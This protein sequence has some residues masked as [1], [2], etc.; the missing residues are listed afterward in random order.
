MGV[1]PE[2]SVVDEWGRAHDVPNLYVA[3]GSVFVTGAA[4]NPS[5]TISALA[6]R[7]SFGMINA[8]QRGEL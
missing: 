5:L 6:T 1:N 7:V 3:D 4:V 2:Y 8:F